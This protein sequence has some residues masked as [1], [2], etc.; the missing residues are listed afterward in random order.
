M[1]LLFLWLVFVVWNIL[2]KEERARHAAND[3]KAQ[4]AAL[5][6]R[7]QTLQGNID[8]LG[9]E[10]GQEASYRETYG[11]ARPGEE[12]IIVVPPGDNEDLGELPWWRKLLGSLGL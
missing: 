3:A 7:Q 5:A 9:T 6:E 8:D 11:V 4:L 2:M 12:V 1:C 10:R